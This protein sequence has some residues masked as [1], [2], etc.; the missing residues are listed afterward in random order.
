MLDPP[1]LGAEAI[2]FAFSLWYVM[3]I[4]PALGSGLVITLH[5]WIELFRTRSWVD[6]AATSWN[7]YAMVHNV[8]SAAESLG[9]AF[10]TVGEWLSYVFTFRGGDSSDG[11]KGALARLMLM[12]VVLALIGGALLTAVI[13]KRNMGRLPVPDVPSSGEADRL[14]ARS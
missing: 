14:A 5:S 6:L 9:P 2:K 4:I 1:E 8:S 11:A 12:I 13:I 7:T 3:V 10:D